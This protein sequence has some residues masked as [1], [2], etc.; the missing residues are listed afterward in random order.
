MSSTLVSGPTEAILFDAQFSV[1]DGEKLVKMIKA[2]GKT[3]KE[4]V[5]TS[6][7]PDFYFGLEPIVKAFPQVSVVASPQVVKHIEETKA[8]KPGLLGAANERG[9]A[10]DPHRPQPV[11]SARFTVDG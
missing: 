5:I 4:I 1:Q 7:D 2:S 6:G 11:A 10:T 3:L 9:C 8:A